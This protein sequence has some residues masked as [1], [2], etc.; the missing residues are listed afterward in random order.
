[1]RAT[2]LRICILLVACSPFAGEAGNGD[3]PPTDVASRKDGGA[4]TGDDASPAFPDGGTKPD[5][6]SLAVPLT[7]AR[8]ASTRSM[9]FDPGSTGW[10]VL[11]TVDRIDDPDRKSTVGRFLWTASGTTSD[12]ST[13]RVQPPIAADPEWARVEWDATTLTGDPYG[14][15]G[16]SLGPMELLSD[17]LT[18]QGRA[19]LATEFAPFKEKN[20]IYLTLDKWW[21]PYPE[22]LH[23]SAALS[24]YDTA[25]HHYTF[26]MIFHH[27]AKDPTLTLRVLVD[28]ALDR[29]LPHERW[30]PKV[31]GITSNCGVLYQ[32]GSSATV[33]LKMDNIV[34][35][36]CPR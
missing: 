20:G 10:E 7:C 32:E 14:C 8:T 19:Y 26:E 3:T 24:R 27:E 21:E 13:L 29:E 31:D 4:S 15:F 6:G 34:L 16:C 2:T 17:E 9:T 1:M 22:K 36:V 33:E 23:R 5:A 30:V 11:G 12:R 18:E 25:W 28:G 35:T